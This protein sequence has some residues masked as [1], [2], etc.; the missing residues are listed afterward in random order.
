MMSTSRRVLLLDKSK[1]DETELPPKSAFYKL[2]VGKELKDEH[3]ERAKRL[4]T[5]HAM[6]MLRNWHHF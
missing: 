5:M 4:W 6:T 3:Y 1:L 2:L